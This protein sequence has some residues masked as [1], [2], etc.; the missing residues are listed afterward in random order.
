MTNLTTSQIEA[1]RAEAAQAGDFAMV[2]ICNAA[3]DGDSD[4]MAECARVIV[5]A[6]A[7]Q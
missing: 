2:D 1:L 7:Q 3:L 5:D 4:A 6:A